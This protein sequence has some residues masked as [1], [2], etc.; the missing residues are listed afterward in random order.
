MDLDTV[1]MDLGG[2]CNTFWITYNSKEPLKVRVGWWGEG[3]SQNN[4]SPVNK[5]ELF[6]SFWI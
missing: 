4:I 3:L 6:F 1:F 5:L 2:L